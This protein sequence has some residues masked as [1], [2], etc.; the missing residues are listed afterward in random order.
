MDSMRVAD[1]LRSL[2]EFREKLIE[3]RELW[4]K[5]LS[6]PIPSYPVRNVDEL[7]KQSQWLTRRVGA[8]RPYIERFDREWVMQH[9]A[10]GAVW[11]ALDA[12]VGLSAVSQIKGPSLRSATEKLNTIAGRLEALDQDD[13]VPADRGV[14][15][16]SGMPADRIMA[17]YLSHLHPYIA[18]GCTK[19]FMDGHY[20]QAVEESAK[21]VFQ[22]LREVSG[23]TLDGAALAQQSFSPKAPILAFS[24][25]SDE[26]KKNEQLG[27]MEM[28][29]AYAKGVRNPL[30][31]TH[32]K[33][34]E[35]QKA[36]E[37]LCMASLFCRRIDD[38]SPKPT[39]AADANP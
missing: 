32:G 39:A 38:A 35:Q 8:L 26:T 16:K 23:L 2:D 37:Y 7:E 4:G 28:L 33:L 31:H 12:S 3:H 14:P 13:I 5:S 10:T 21:A 20:A 9:P 18:Q 24:D 27:F 19:L 11:D 1:L 30:A 17:A 22:Y 15:L 34:E 6:Q 36:F 29:S 25:L